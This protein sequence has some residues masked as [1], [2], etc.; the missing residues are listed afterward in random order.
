MSSKHR[1]TLDSI[2]STPARRRL[3]ARAQDPEIV[4]RREFHRE[5]TNQRVTFTLYDPGFGP[6]AKGTAILV[7]YSPGGALLGHIRFDE[8][9]WPDGEFS[10]RFRVTGGEFEGVHAYGLPVR[11]ATTSASLAMKFDGLYV[12]I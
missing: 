3:E 7:D 11:F 12:K 10:I 8:G 2:M 5:L 1:A 6:V 9:F 4:C